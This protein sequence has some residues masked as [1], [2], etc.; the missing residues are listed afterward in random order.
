MKYVLVIAGSDSGGGAGIQADIKT[1][2]H[3]ECHPLTVLTAV[4]AQNSL[5]IAAI[6]KIP[7]RFISS[8][9]ETVL[10]DM[11][12]DA[13]KI[14]MLY[15]NPAVNEV[16]R[17]IK[18]YSLTNVVVDP[19]LKSSTGTDLAESSVIS[20]LKTVLL[21][22]ATVVTPNLFEAGILADK[23][24]RGPHEMVEAAKRIKLS[25]PDVVITGGHLK[26]KCMDILYDGAHFHRFSGSRIDTA[27]THGSGCVF[28]TALATFMARGETVVHA[29]KLAHEFTRTAIMHAYGC[30][31]GSGPVRP[32][33]WR[34]G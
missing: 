12:P 18:K 16:A 25:G 7:A 5:G 10:D 27:N 2:T 15:S 4:T 8:Q 14:G 29:T 23:K 33:P 26:D 30:G 20:T 13:V 22:I 31:R 34:R 32:G 21:P 9:L 28:S 11:I 6:H 19:V 17:Q 3:L 24:V 1:I